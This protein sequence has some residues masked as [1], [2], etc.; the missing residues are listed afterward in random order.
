MRPYFWNQSRSQETFSTSRGDTLLDLDHRNPSE[1]KRA[2]VHELGGTSQDHTPGQCSWSMA[3]DIVSAVITDFARNVCS[4][5]SASRNI[6]GELA[7]GQLIVLQWLSFS[8]DALRWTPVV[9]ATTFG[10]QV[11]VR[12]SANLNRLVPDFRLRQR[13]RLHVSPPSLAVSF[14][15]ARRGARRSKS[16]VKIE[17]P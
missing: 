5:G 9:K 13:A 1:K 11:R 6:R 7:P 10:P 17:P 8:G 2:R 3:D 15:N 4:S 16:R 12:G 14:I